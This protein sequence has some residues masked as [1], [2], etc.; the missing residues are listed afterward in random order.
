MKSGG[1]PSR[2]MTQVGT[3]ATKHGVSDWESNESTYVGI[4]AG[5]AD[6]KVTSAELD[7]YKATIATNEEQAKWMQEGYDDAK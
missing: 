5:M 3:V 2:L 7:G 4:G 6:A 1:D